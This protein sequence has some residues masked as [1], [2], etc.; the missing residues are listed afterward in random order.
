M[1]FNIDDFLHTLKPY[2]FIGPDYMFVHKSRQV[3]FFDLAVENEQ[4]LRD[5][6]NCIQFTEVLLFD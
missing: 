4:K 5:V 6:H 2:F 1:K 3:Y